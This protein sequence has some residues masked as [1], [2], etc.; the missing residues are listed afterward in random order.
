[1][2]E[3]VVII[4]AII[5]TIYDQCDISIGLNIF[6]NIFYV[7]SVLRKLLYPRNIILVGWFEGVA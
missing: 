6:L 5:I 7:T 4:I 1:M 2:F 3:S